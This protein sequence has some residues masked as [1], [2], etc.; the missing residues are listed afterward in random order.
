MTPKQIK[1]LRQR[2]ELTQKD[3]AEKLYTKRLTIIRWE[4]GVHKPRGV[5]L[6]MLR[7]MAAKARRKGRMKA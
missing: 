7:E 1:Q 5:F 3:F 4:G 6:K 2:L